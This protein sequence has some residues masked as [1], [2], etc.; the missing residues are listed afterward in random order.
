MSEAKI[1]FTVTVGE[2]VININLSYLSIAKNPNDPEANED[3]FDYEGD[4]FVLADG[5]TAKGGS[6]EVEQAYGESGGKVAATIVCRAALQTDYNEQELVSAVSEQLMDS[7]KSMY[8]AAIDD[9]R[10]RFAATMLVARVQDES[11]VIT[12]VGD[13]GFRINGNEVFSQNNLVDVLDAQ[14]RSFA[15]RQALELGFDEAAAP[16]MGRDYIQPLLDNQHRYRNNPDHWLGFPY[17][18]GGPVPE[19]FIKNYTFP[20]NSISTFEMFSDGFPVVPVDTTIKAWEESYQRVKSEDPWRYKEF[21]ATKPNDD[22][23]VAILD[24]VPR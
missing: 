16:G 24:L 8:P 23:T 3:L 10:L 20:I 13:C 17:I 22:R 6:Q 18:D 15:I 7:Y 4:S 12:Q 14:S 19:K 1:P 2:E 21:P 9:P 5:S 11:L